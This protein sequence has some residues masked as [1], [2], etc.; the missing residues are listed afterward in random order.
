MAQAVS[1]ANIPTLL[2]VLVHLTGDLQWLDAPYQP[3]RT[4]GLDDNDDGGLPDDIQREVRTAATEAITAWLDGTPAALPLPQDDELL[5]RMLAV[6]MGEEVPTSYAPMIR[7]ELELAADRAAAGWDLGAPAPYVPRRAPSE[8]DGPTVLVVGAGISGIAASV[9]LQRAG[10]EHVIVERG[11]T[12]GGVWRDNRYPGCGVDTPSHI[13]TFSFASNDWTRYF[14]LREEIADYLERVADDHDVRSRVCFQ[15]E[16]IAASWDEVAQQWTTT[17]RAPDGSTEELVSDVVVTAVGA[18]NKPVLPD[19]P[20]RDD[21]HGP[22]L[23]TARWPE[24]GVDLSGMRVAVIGSGASAMQVVPE[25][26]EQVEHLIVFQRTPQWVAPFDAFRRRFP[27]GVRQLLRTVPWYHAWYRTRLGWVYNDRIHPSLQLSGP[28]GRGRS[29]SSRR[30]VTSTLGTAGSSSLGSSN[31]GTSDDARLPEFREFVAAETEQIT[32]DIG[33]VRAHRGSRVANGAGRARHFGHHPLHTDWAKFLVVD[34][35]N[36]VTCE[37]VGIVDEIRGRH[38]GRPRRVV[39]CEGLV[40]LGDGPRAH[41][42][43]DG[44]LELRP[45]LETGLEVVEPVVILQGHGSQDVHDAAFGRG[46][47]RVPAAV[48]RLPGADVGVTRILVPDAL[49]RAS[50]LVLDDDLLL[51]LPVQGLVQ[52]DIDHLPLATLGITPVQGHGDAV[53]RPYARHGVTE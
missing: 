19:V 23:H 39:T 44:C 21:F 36:H 22:T 30:R 37:D 14:A 25:L 17:V 5:V 11:T 43:S 51:D 26:A 16:A 8:R 7:H 52:S 34:R 46:A 3:T 9:Q 2:M 18:F 1:E 53:R 31:S 49:E 12:I 27:D 4:V 40:D 28:C 20:G 13:Y 45:V 24:E 6:A 33:V 48:L 38:H 15:R 10:Y 50:Q 41:P 32:V 29:S 35:D 47:E 42:R